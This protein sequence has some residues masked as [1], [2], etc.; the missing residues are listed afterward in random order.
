[1]KR[2]MAA[3]IKIG[4]LLGAVG[5]GVAFVNFS[6]ES[7]YLSLLYQQHKNTGDVIFLKR[8]VSAL[9]TE[10]E[11]LSREMFDAKTSADFVANLPVLAE[12]SGISQFTMQS[13]GSKTDGKQE[14]M[15]VELALQGRFAAIAS[16][17]DIL[18]RARLPI[19]IETLVMESSPRLINATMM[20]KIYYRR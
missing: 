14:V 7:R 15:T 5:A 2:M 6:K 1:M 8:T 12:F 17:V 3:I 4:L 11:N 18:E 10:Y 19:Q 13:K 9:K 16:F 20:I